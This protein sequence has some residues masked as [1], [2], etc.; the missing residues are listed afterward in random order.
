MGTTTATSQPELAAA[1]DLRGSLRDKVL[2]PADA[3]YG[4]ARQIWN[5]AVSHQPALFAQ[6]QSVEDVCAAVRVAR[7]HGLPL[8]VRGGGHDWAGRSLR[9]N[10]VVIDLSPMRHV[11]AD[12]KR[13]IATIG[14]GAS[15]RDI[16]AAAAPYGL[17][18]VTGNCG[19]V[20][21][22]GLTLG[23]GYGALS[24]KY[25]LAL[26]NLLGV[27]IV[28]ADGRRICADA[29]E[30][31]DLFWALRGGG[32]NFG[33]VTSMRIRLHPV[34]EVLAGMILYPWTDAHSVLHGYAAAMADAPDEFAVM[35]GVLSAPDGSPVLFLSPTW[36]G[37][38][39]DGARAIA[40]LQRLG[41]PLLTQVGTMSY[42][43]MLGMYDAHIV[44]GRHY[45][46][47]TR[48]L[49]E[50]APSIIGDITATAAARTSPLSVIALHHFHGAAARVRTGETAFGLRREHFLLEIVACWEPESN[51]DGT[52]H[53]RWARTASES[54]AS[55][56]LPGGYPNL[57]GPAERLQID[58]A[59]G[60]NVGRLLDV[61][62]RFDSDNVFSAIPLPL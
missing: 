62:R 16:V 43:D 22:A 58:R 11:E 3:D 51:D 23:G 32:G 13:R 4:R 41:S 1:T 37:D 33:V 34:R 47:Q 38:P 15:A 17:V 42:G 18:A 27:D 29:H 12:P 59:F 2:V 36:C 44:S 6:C 30:H 14:G 50:L 20:G 26:D 28:L 53:R 5:G 52:T 31:P 8:S 35:A 45:A 9:H 46:I 61:K 49:A 21:M 24:P 19:D 55:R 25:G 10:G 54:L 60:D 56:A 40:G 7:R 57:L 48:W 39:A